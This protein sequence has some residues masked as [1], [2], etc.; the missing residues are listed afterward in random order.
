MLCEKRQRLL[1]GEKLRSII[2]IYWMLAGG[3]NG[4]PSMW[5]LLFEADNLLTHWCNRWQCKSV[6]NLMG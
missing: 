4:G 6:L 5:K 2:T 3:E 1:A